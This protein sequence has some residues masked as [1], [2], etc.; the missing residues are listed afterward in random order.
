[1]RGII[2]GLRLHR[3]IILTIFL[4]E[5]TWKPMILVLQTTIET[6]PDTDVAIQE[7]LKKYGLRQQDA[8]ESFGVDTFSYYRIPSHIDPKA[9]IHDLMELSGVAAAY[10]KSG[11]MAPH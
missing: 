4:P 8:S 5:I 10:V 1:M 9:I 11:G 3:R 7:V 6:K 2:S